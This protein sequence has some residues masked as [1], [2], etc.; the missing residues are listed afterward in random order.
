MSKWQN[1]LMLD[2][3]LD[4]VADADL[5]TVCTS[6][7]T[8]YAEA[9]TNVGSGGYKLAD[10]ALVGGD[11]TKADGD[12]SGRK[13]TIGEKASVD[14]DVT[15]SAQHVALVTIGTTTLRY[16][17]TKATETINSGTQITI[18]AWDIEL[19]DSA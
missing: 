7:P 9:T 6:Q 11:F 12:V 1:D 2:A 4:Y 17:T 18:P 13:L 10:V 14:V 5:M 3:A 15:G 8:S 16:V 19:R